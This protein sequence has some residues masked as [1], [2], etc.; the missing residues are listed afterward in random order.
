DINVPCAS[1][2]KS[3]QSV[4][5]AFSSGTTSG[6]ILVL[7]LAGA[8]YG[9]LALTS[10]I[11]DATCNASN[12]SISIGIVGNTNPNA[13][14]YKW[15]TN[16][17]QYT[18]S[19]TGL[20]AGTYICTI[21]DISNC[22]GNYNFTVNPVAMA[23]VT[24]TPAQASICPGGST[25]INAG[26]TGPAVSGYTWN[27]GGQTGS[28]ISVSPAATT[29]YTVT[30][31]DANGCTVS[32]T[33]TVTVNPVPTSTFTAGPDSVCQGG[34]ATVTFTGNA[35]STAVYDWS[36]FAGAAVQT[37]SGSGPYTIQFNTPGTYTLQLQVT[38]GCPSAVSSKQI[39][40]SEKPQPDFTYG[41]SPICAGGTVTVSFSG[42]ASATSKPTWS[43][44]GGIV[45]NGSGF[46][47]YT[48]LYNNTGLIK[49]SV[50]NGACNVNA[51]AKIVNVTPNAF[52]DFDAQ[53]PG[54]CIPVNVQFVNK[55]T[56]GN[57]YKWTFGD[58]Q[59]STAANPAHTYSNTGAYTVTLDVSNNG[60]CP[61]SITKTNFI[62]VSTPPTIAFS[63]MPDTTVV[64]EVH[65]AEFMFF[66][67]SQGATSWLWKFGDG[68]TSTDSDPTHK[69]NMAGNYTVTL[70]GTNGACVDSV[71]HQYYKVI[72]DKDIK[73]PNAFS[74]NGDGINDRWEIEALKQFPDCTVTVFNRW[75]Q[76]VFKSQGYQRP[77]DGS[78]KGQALPLATYY[79]VITLP[80]KKPYSGWVVILK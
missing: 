15:N 35:S 65:Q 37:G 14:F 27:P 10:S 60:Q 69:Y 26:A 66:N 49:L 36:N 40:V 30:G 11:T 52:A 77:W 31:Q 56:D 18:P 41:P 20:P 64:L 48:V 4:D 6:R 54:G 72:P 25:T 67:Q 55:S 53:P 33:T 2:P 68:S 75:G 13:Y 78:F 39:V 32:G 74:P 46:G 59:T 80:G 61:G 3:I 24:A 19:I 45:Q 7:A 63:S 58:G 47:P 1:R 29:T 51:T 22:S 9:P 8:P 5:I 21:T 57:T 50:K 42:Y 70:I 71:S 17:A 34:T 12:G 79:Y 23:T 76:E 44:G 73:I 28:S 43:W 16:P 62:N 38:D